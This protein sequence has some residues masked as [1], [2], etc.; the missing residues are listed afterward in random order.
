MGDLEFRPDSGGYYLCLQCHERAEP[1]TKI[2]RLARLA[3]E[4]A[5]LPRPEFLST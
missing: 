1:A 4:R 2:T 3:D 5:V